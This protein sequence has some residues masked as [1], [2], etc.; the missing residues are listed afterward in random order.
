MN[1][2]LDASVTMGWLLLDGKPAERAYALK[3]LDAMKQAETSALVPVTWGLE[4]SNV[5]SKAEMKGLVREA[6]SEA[7]LEMLEGVVISADSATFS[8]ALSDTLQIARRYRLS[9]YDASYLELAMRERLPLATLDEDL[10]KA[11]NKAGVKRFA[12]R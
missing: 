11:A 2:V 9:A 6:Q 10:Q 4:V 1:F 7:F 3:V 12:V 8:K 5:I